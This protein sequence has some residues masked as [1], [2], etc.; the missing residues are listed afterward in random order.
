MRPLRVLVADDSAFNRRTIAD[1]LSQ[2]P[3]VEIVGKAVDGEQALSLAFLEKPDLVTLDLEMPRMD[4]FTFLKILMAKQPTPVIVISSRSAKVDV[5]RALELGALDF[6]IK[7]SGGSPQELA[8]IREELSAKVAMVRQLRPLRAPERVVSSTFLRPVSDERTGPTE[9]LPRKLVVIG[10]S[11]G[12]PPAL[13]RMF[14]RFTADLPA[15]FVIAQHMP[16]RFT[17]TF[18]DRLERL[19]GLHVSEIDDRATIRAGRAFVCPGGFCVEIHARPAGLFAQVVAPTSDD[20]YVPSV[21]RLFR[22]AAEVFGPR[23]VAVVLTGMG[24]D[25]TKGAQAVRDAG[26]LVLCESEESAAIHGM[27]GSVVRAGLAHEIL[28]LQ[29]LSERV[30][31]LVRE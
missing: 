4:G 14:A 23:V 13:V 9:S 20:R 27:P 17:K 25:G 2:L 22:T 10:A 5:F 1:I 21:D 26:G 28:S 7:P 16:E 12:G 11:T 18:A 24:D 6:V 3:G 29:A 30:V 15:T 19:G 8:T 31:K